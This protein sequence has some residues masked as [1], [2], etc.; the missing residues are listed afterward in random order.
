MCVCAFCNYRASDVCWV[1]VPG[2]L[3]AWDVGYVVGLVRCVPGWVPGVSEVGRGWWF[4][5]GGG[6]RWVWVGCGGGR[7]KLTLYCVCAAFWYLHVFF[8]PF[9][10]AHT[11]I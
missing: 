2:R 9:V 10:F 3:H 5:G 11:L 8:A 6:G 4:G 7:V 1:G